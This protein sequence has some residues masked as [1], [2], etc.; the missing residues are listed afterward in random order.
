MADG[1]SKMCEAALDSTKRRALR[2]RAAA[3]ALAWALG[4]TLFAARSAVADETA[5][6]PPDCPTA[7]ATRDL[8]ALLR[9]YAPVFVAHESEN[10]FNRIGTPKLSPGWLGGV[11]LRVD[12]AAPTMY[13][14][15]R[16]DAV[17]GQ[18][19]TQLVYRVHFEKIPFRMSRYW[20]EAHRN[21]GMLAVVTLD[22]QSLEPQFATLVHTCGCYRAVVPT[23]AVPREMLPAEWTETRNLYGQVLPGRI[24]VPELGESRIVV[25]L[26]P[27]GHRVSGIRVDR[28]ARSAGVPIEIRDLSELRDMPVAGREGRTAS[29]F[30]QSWPL[31]GKV[32]GAWNMFEGFS[33][34]FLALDP[35]VGMDKDFGDPDVTGTRFY[36]MLTPWKRDVSRLDKFEALLTELGYRMPESRTAGAE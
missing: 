18:Q 4:A 23:E 32:R 29:M 15:V 21:P 19:M 8:D 14:E 28:I 26:E 34:G 33:L 24:P 31:R 11:S 22:S 27:F 35:M 25:D 12:P 5:Y 2:S 16:E 10:A 1:G 36:T 30:Y 17:A 3:T 9:C 7:R 13:A 20:F 6:I